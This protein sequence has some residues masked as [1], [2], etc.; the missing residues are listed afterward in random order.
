M[1][2]EKSISWKLIVILFIAVPAVL[3]LL[4]SWYQNTYDKLPV[5]GQAEII[6]GKKHEHTV[7]A[8]TL[9]NQD[10]KQFSSAQLN[11][12]IAIANFFFTSC[13]S[14]CPRMMKNIVSV[15]NKFS[16]NS[17]IAFVSFTVD[18]ETDSAQRLKWCAKLIGINTSNWN[19]LTGNKKEIYKLARNSFY[20]TATDGDGGANDFIHSDQV[21]LI[22]KQKQIRGYYDG[23]DDRAMAQLIHDINKLGNEN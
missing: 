2:K 22:D 9:E 7:D 4:I 17:E 8:F 21:V 11:N 14:I 6:N 5:Y 15:E 12:K 13:T 23:T 1:M 20:L 16:N 10:G 3:F 18:P 19:L